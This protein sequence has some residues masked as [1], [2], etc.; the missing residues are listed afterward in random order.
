MTSSELH[1]VQPKGQPIFTVIHK[2]ENEIAEE[3][4]IYAGSAPDSVVVVGPDNAKLCEASLNEIDH[5]EADLTLA[6]EDPTI[7]E[8][9][10]LAQFAVDVLMVQDNVQLVSLDIEKGIDLPRDTISKEKFAKNIGFFA[11]KNI[12]SPAPIYQHQAKLAA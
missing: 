10:E 2:L 9:P 3:F 1:S 6:V 8:K 11:V 4:G 7:F 5:G 12:Y